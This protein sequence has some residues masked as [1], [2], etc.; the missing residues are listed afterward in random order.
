MRFALLTALVASL[1]ATTVARHLPLDFSASIS[2]SQPPIAS[3]ALVPRQNDDSPDGSL[4]H[5]PDDS[6]D[7]SQILKRSPPSVPAGQVLWKKYLDKGYSMNCGMQG[8]D[9]AA[10]FM[11]YGLPTATTAASPWV[12]GVSDC[13][14]WY[15]WEGQQMAPCDMDGHYKMG[16]MFNQLHISTGPSGPGSAQGLRCLHLAHEDDTLTQD[17]PSH[18]DGESKVKP[19]DQT[20]RVDGTSYHV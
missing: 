7:Y 20:Y 4:N 13:K 18:P 9:R 16:T 5:S 1:A 8:N 17:D 19:Y 2:R 15:W 6:L 10:A 14:T 11:I 12:H 3:P